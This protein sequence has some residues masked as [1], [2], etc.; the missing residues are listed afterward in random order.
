MAKHRVVA[1]WAVDNTFALAMADLNRLLF[2]QN[3]NLNF[4]L[5]FWF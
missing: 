1:L 2:I 5:I 3:K 4:V